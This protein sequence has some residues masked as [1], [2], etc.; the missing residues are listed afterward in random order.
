M[1]DRQQ[2]P[3]TPTKSIYASAAGFLGRLI[4]PSKNTR[5][6]CPS[7]SRSKLPVPSATS[8]SPQKNFVADPRLSFA[9]KPP[10]NV[11]G[12]IP[13]TGTAA[14]KVLAELNAR[15]LSRP[16]ASPHSRA[17][18]KIGGKGMA[19]SPSVTQKLSEKQD[20][21]MS[22]A[23][24]IATHWSTQ[25]RSVSA[26]SSHS[27]PGSAGSIRSTTTSATT[28]TK[29]AQKPKLPTVLASPEKKRVTEETQ[30]G[31]PAKRMKLDPA[32][33]RLGMPR[34]PSKM[35]LFGSGSGSGTTT[36]ATKTGIPRSPS[37]SM[38]SSATSSKLP[39]PTST[40]TTKD[41]GVKDVST[42]NAEANRRH[43][44]LQRQRRRDARL[45][46][47][48]SPVKAR[49]GVKKAPAWK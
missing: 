10:T 5:S 2:D 41:E 28:T 20:K 43:L 49:A 6:P 4:S 9:P 8:T 37:K 39:I 48:V 3:T 44:E 22:K 40:T 42:L 23:D 14:D 15:S 34:S 38:L 30:G 7:P 25:S 46:G 31:T 13:D 45:T 21:L 16:V 11:P 19:R 1:L 27:R 12:K 26:A 17:L 32:S 36:A 24:S 29:A 47:T 33:S 35:N 18:S